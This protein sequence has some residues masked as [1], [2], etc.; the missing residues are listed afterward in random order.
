MT[1]SCAA[2][3]L[4]AVLVAVTTGAQRAQA[5]ATTI[6]RTVYV[7][8]GSDTGVGFG[9]FE[10]TRDLQI[11]FIPTGDWDILHSEI[12]DQSGKHIWQHLIA[13]PKL[14]RWKGFGV[15]I[16]FETGGDE[17]ASHWV[18]FHGVLGKSSP[19]LFGG[20]NPEFTV[21]VNDI[22]IDCDSDNDSESM[23]RAAHTAINRDEFPEEAE[24]EDQCE[25]PDGYGSTEPPE[26]MLVRPV[27]YWNQMTVR[28]NVARPGWL[29]LQ[30]PTDFAI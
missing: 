19:G 6:E 11:D 7:S 5:Q 15:W 18:R 17:E 1:R 22:D 21:E 9:N 23:W 27:E 12:V 8:P 24:D 3:C 16:D 14:H 10:E 2:S 26:E 4:L 20:R 25:F 29:S 30:V 28:V 13:T